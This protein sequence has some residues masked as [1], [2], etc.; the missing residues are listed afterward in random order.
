MVHR[1]FAAARRYAPA[2]LFVDEIDTFAKKR[3]GGDSATAQVTEE[4][5]TAFFSE[6]D[7]FS[8]DDSKPVIVLGATNYGVDS[9]DGMSLDPAMLRRFDRRILIDVPTQEN[10]RIFLSRKIAESPLF[11]VSEGMIA[12]LAERSAGMSLALLSSML[13]M[14]MRS[15]LRNG[16][17]T[18]GDTELE[19]A[20]E[21]FNSGEK[22]VRSRE[23]MLRTARHE[24]GHTVISW[25][26]GEKPS[27]VTIVSRGNHGGYMQHADQEER[28]LYTRSELLTRIRTALGGRAAEIVCYG[29][30]NGVSTGASSDLRSATECARA[31]L[32]SY[33]MD[34][35]FGLAVIGAAGSETESAIRSAVNGILR[36]QLLEAIRLITENR[37]RFDRLVNSLLLYN[38]LKGE[39]IDKCLEK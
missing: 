31:M 8:K 27:Y 21:T 10:R 34:D 19:E 7:G 32:C 33:G 39:D 38:S 37:S 11:D 9:N 26:A 15:S 5:L 28:L 36:E 18:I 12:S 24:A 20:F 25:L 23:A 22:R 1:L 4:I 35:E 17:K 13:E 3:T 16:G 6:M 14:A 30:E 29:S 2:V